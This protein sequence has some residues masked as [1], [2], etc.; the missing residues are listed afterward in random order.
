[1]KAV[2][3]A[4]YSSSNQ[5]EESID[6]Q[7]RECKAFAARND[8]SIV[9]TY[10]DRALSAKTDNRPEFL[11]MIQDSAKK[12]FDRVI[13]YTLDRF[14][15]NR[16][17]SA[18][19]RQK[20]KKNGVVVLSAKENI[21][22]DSSGIILE[23]VLE[24]YAEYYSVELAQKVLRG[25][26]ENAMNGRWAGGTVPL[27]YVLNAEKHLEI[28]PIGAKIVQEIFQRFA[29]GE[30]SKRIIDDLNA[31]GLRTVKGNKFNRGSL[32]RMF[33]NEKY[34]GTFQWGEIVKPNAIP[35][36][37]DPELFLLVQKK[38]ENKKYLPRIKN[39]N[40]TFL[41]SGKV[42]CGKCGS[43][44]R[45]DVGTSKTNG[46]RHSYY[47]CPGKRKT[48]TCDQKSIKK[49]ALEKLVLKETV[50][51]LS[52]PGIIEEI[53]NQAVIA[54]SKKNNDLPIRSLENQIKDIKIKL[55]NCMKAID[56][57]MVSQTLIDRIANYETD[58]QDLQ[59]QLSH[60]KIMNRPFILEKDHIIFFLEKMLEA[61]EKNTNQ[62]QDKII[63]TF[64]RAVIVRDQEIEIQYNYSD[65]QNFSNNAV[66]S[67]SSIDFLVEFRNRWT[68][69]VSF[70]A[71]YFSQKISLAA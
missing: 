41:L 8:L 43:V 6:G 38:I 63:S 61:A 62:H 33:E 39:R 64:I 58:L 46:Q 10:I 47:S 68:N 54:Q 15:R 45:G 57:G 1:M 60:E 71:T 69:P 49:D 3:Y 29:A 20:L 17:D 59:I 7:I 50:A 12:Q 53:A 16:Y 48:K 4:R 5:R 34:I 28:E 27:G 18:V 22:D 31:R 30:Q 26:N 40:E 23:S 67:G 32:H 52:Q 55:E 65:S 70:A 13:V 36:I 9:G 66:V 35:A 25:M 21:S 24:A 19:Y 11:Q 51:M 56:S 42:I 2:I 14:A 44:F 37:I